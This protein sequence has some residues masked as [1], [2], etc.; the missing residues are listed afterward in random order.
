MVGSWEND[1]GASARAQP[2]LSFLSLHSLGRLTQHNT[3]FHEIIIVPSHLLEINDLVL[4]RLLLRLLP[5]HSSPASSSTSRRSTF[6]LL[7]GCERRRYDNTSKRACSWWERDWC[8]GVAEVRANVGVVRREEGQVRE[9]VERARQMGLR[10]S[11][12]RQCGD[13][14]REQLWEKTDELQGGCWGTYEAERKAGR[15]VAAAREDEVWIRSRW[16]GTTGLLSK[17]SPCLDVALSDS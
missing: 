14:V 4:P 6:A 8:F 5:S 10:E 3:L 7:V 9:E 16:A 2:T 17:L 13:T 11:W 15:R 12:E 1:D